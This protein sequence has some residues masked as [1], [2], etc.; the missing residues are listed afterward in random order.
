MR[1]TIPCLFLALGGATAPLAAQ[2]TGFAPVTPRVR[3]ELVAAR[4]AVWR[5][6]FRADTAQLTA[7]LPE[8]MI[9]MG[10]TRADVIADAT[11]FVRDGGRYEGITFTDD[12]FAVQG[13]MAVIYSHYAVRLSTRGKPWTM[14]GRAVELF[15]KRNGRWINPSWHLKEDAH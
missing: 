11:G 9:G 3:A 2:A 7:L 5:A 6:Y 4:E 8:R 15:V 12:E 14:A 13:D 1:R 10:K